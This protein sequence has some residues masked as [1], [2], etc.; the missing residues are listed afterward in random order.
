[1]AARS[2]GSPPIEKAGPRQ[3]TGR[4]LTAHTSAAQ[5]SESCAQQDV[6]RCRVCRHPLRADV[7]VGRGIGPVCRRR[8]GVAS[9]IH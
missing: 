8:A 9:C 2:G 1:M 3:E 4:F 5:H 6:P 7:S